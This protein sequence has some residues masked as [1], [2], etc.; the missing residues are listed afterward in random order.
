MAYHFIPAFLPFFD[1]LPPLLPFRSFIPFR[2]F[3][4]CMSFPPCISSLPSI[5]SHLTPF[6]CWFL[7]TLSFSFLFSYLVPT[8]STSLPSAGEGDACVC[9][10]AWDL[11][12]YDANCAN[13]IGC[14]DPACDDDSPWCVVANP[15]C[16]TEESGG[17]WTYCDAN[18]SIADGAW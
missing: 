6:F 15:G 3:L 11:S 10:A 7:I 18:T 9:L 14:P 17:G 12:E 4:P 13:Q 16:P 5:L 8:D 2:S 1:T